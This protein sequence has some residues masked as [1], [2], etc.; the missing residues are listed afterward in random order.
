MI[1][2][3]LGDALQVVGAVLV[4]VV[5]LYVYGTL[6]WDWLY[7]SLVWLRWLIFGR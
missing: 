2:K 1:P 3:R 5:I 4:W 7:G 6:A